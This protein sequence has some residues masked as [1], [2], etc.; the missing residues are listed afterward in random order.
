VAATTENEAYVLLHDLA[1]WKEDE[2]VL[3]WIKNLSI[4]DRVKLS[5]QTGKF[6]TEGSDAER[7][8]VKVI[9][10]D[11]EGWTRPNYLAAKAKLGAIIA[12]KAKIYTE[13]RD[14]KVTARYVSGMT[15]VAVFNEGSEGDYLKV[16][17]YDYDQKVLLNDSTFV[18]KS[19]VTMQ[20]VDINA[21][22]LYIASTQAKTV[23]LKINLL[24]TIMDKYSG[25]F[26]APQIETALNDLKG[27]STK[28]STP[29]SGNFLVLEDK[30]NIRETSD[31]INGKILGVLAKDTIIT[32]TDMTTESYTI[33]GKTAPWYKMSDPQGWVFGAFL[34]PAQ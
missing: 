28:P 17:G 31:E 16:A 18:S 22:T 2:G 12:T 29:T 10:G 19:D 30:V 3:K 27:I 6:K 11:K 5:D 7:D 26:F 21:I 20:E 34:T 9:Y 25:S 24:S 4:G 8:Y 13:P 14:I 15:L 33:N 32:V 1:L 23:E